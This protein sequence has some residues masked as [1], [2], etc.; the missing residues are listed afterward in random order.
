MKK[1][2]IIGI[3]LLSIALLRYYRVHPL[4]TQVE[5][6]GNRFIVELAVT[7]EEKKQGLGYRDSLLNNRG[8]LFVYDH[9]EQY[10]FWMKG[11]RFPL[12]IIWIH[13]KKIIDISANVPVREGDAIPVR[14]PKLPVSQI[15]EVNA[16][17]IDRLGIQVGDD[18]KILK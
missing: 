1:A 3:I 13:D 5:I 4:A 6:R 7:D 11:M 2:A 9:P 12:D 16:G 8:M 10:S 18:V 17:T 15:L 14:S